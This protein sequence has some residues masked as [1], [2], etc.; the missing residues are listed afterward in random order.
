M[1]VAGRLLIAVLFLAGL[2]CRAFGGP[3]ESDLKSLRLPDGFTMGLFASGL[4][5]PRFMAFDPSG[6]LYVTLTRTGDVIA[7]PDGDGDGRADR[8]VPAA[9]NLNRP[10]GIAFSDGYVYVAETD[11]VV[12]FRQEPQSLLLREKETA[13]PE[14]PTKGGGHFTRTVAFGPDGMM[15]VSVGSSCNACVEEELER[16]AITRFDPDGG[17]REIYARGLRN[18]VG[19]AFHPATGELFATENGRDWLGDDLPPDEINIIK[20]GGHYGW[21]FCYG[22]RVPD[23]E[24]KRPGF[25]ETT[26]PPVL[27]IQAHSAPLGLAFYT[28]EQFPPRFRGGL[29]VAFHG[30]WN[31]TAPTGYKVVFVPFEKN[32][33]AGPYE[34]FIVGWLR[35][36]SYWGRPAGVAQG[37]S[38]ELYISDDYAGAIYRV[39]YRSR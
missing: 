11:R 33:P 36:G 32:R 34:D 7:L 3:S 25:C 24:F 4:E 19:L 14:L 5:G 39:T 23:R 26:I 35:G 15:Y 12:R 17:N 9:G 2:S 10:H 21:P 29:F 13:V 6:T 31:R 20:Q 8:A 1:P 38:G 16:A 18:S 28:A 27:E 37:P 22:R 30:S